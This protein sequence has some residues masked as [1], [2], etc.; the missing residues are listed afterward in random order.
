MLLRVIQIVGNGFLHRG[1]RLI[2]RSKRKD[3]EDTLR[4]PTNRQV[5]LREPAE[6]AVF[7]EGG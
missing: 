1:G 3:A 6:P 5:R 4:L 2:F 7:S